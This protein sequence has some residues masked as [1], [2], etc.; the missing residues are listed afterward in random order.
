MSKHIFWINSYPKS[1]NTLVRAIISSLF[2]SKDGNFTFD[3]FNYI[4]QF[5]AK[6]KLNF[7]I[8]I[9]KK[10]FLQLDKIEILSKYWQKIQD[11]K[12]LNFNGDFAFLKSH[13]ALFSIQNNFFSNENNTKGYIYIIRDPRDIVISWSKHTNLSL[14]EA[15]NFMTNYNSCI[16][17]V[18]SIHSKLP[19]KTN[20]KS[21]LS[22][23][24]QHVISWTKNNWRTPKIIIKYEDL[25]YDKKN[26]ILQIINFFKK[27]YNIVFDNIDQKINNI[28][29]TTDFEKFKKIENEKGFNEATYGSF[30]R[31]GQKNQWKTILNSNQ[32]K[33][34]ENKFK[35]T[36]LEYDYEL[37]LL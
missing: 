14:D 27:N 15:I 19:S 36:M 33:N 26:T 11:E 5:E 30:F 24:E 23:W 8:D 1:G 16:A 18:D 32:I 25:V 28:I 6:E 3:L 17:W 21:Y 7:I 37:N 31:K 20:P 12:R 2:F 35:T 22:S 10:D 4:G 34:I 13:H 29:K 9:N